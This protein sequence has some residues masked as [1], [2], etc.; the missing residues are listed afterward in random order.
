[1]LPPHP[2]RLSLNWTADHFPLCLFGACFLRGCVFVCSVAFRVVWLFAVF[3]QWNRDGG[4]TM[5]RSHT[6][7]LL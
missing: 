1:M 3:L 7:S 5:Y 4:W 2:H 6:S